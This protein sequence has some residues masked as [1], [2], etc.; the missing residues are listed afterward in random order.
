MG[1][2]PRSLSRSWAPEIGPVEEH[3]RAHPSRECRPSPR[4]SAVGPVRPCGQATRPGKLDLSLRL[5][6]RRSGDCAWLAAAPRAILRSLYVARV[7]SGPS[8][9]SA[10]QAFHLGRCDLVAAPGSP[11]VSSCHFAS[12]ISG[13]EFFL[14]GSYFCTTYRFLLSHP[15]ILSGFLY[16]SSLLVLW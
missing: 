3:V 8:L 6:S 4:T 9:S 14:F 10:S 1:R 16:L 5:L 7:S 15:T 12:S 11:F 2:S 13:S